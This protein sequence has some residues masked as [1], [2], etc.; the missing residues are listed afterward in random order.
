MCKFPGGKY[1]TAPKITET[2]PPHCSDGF[3]PAEGPEEKSKGHPR[4][5]LITGKTLPPR[6]PPA[7]AGIPRPGHLLAPERAPQEGDPGPPVNTWKRAGRASHARAAGQPGGAR[8]G[9][10]G[11]TSARL[12][13][14]RGAAPA[15]R[16]PPGP[17]APAL[18]AGPRPRQRGS[19][20]RG[21]GPRRRR[22]PPRAL[23]W[24][25][26]PWLHVAG[27]AR[28]A[29][30]RCGNGCGAGRGGPGLAERP[31]P[32]PAPQDSAA[33]ACPRPGPA[34]SALLRRPRTIAGGGAGAGRLTWAARARAGLPEGPRCTRPPAARAACAPGA[35][36]GSR[37]SAADLGFP[38]KPSTRQGTRP[39]GARRA[40]PRSRPG[41]R[42]LEG[43][44][45]RVAL[46]GGGGAQGRPAPESRLPCRAP[47][48]RSARRPASEQPLTLV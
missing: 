20:G 46:P 39:R 3:L 1:K 27:R 8:A 21:R 44:R 29:G 6:A 40:R 12:P 10:T 47:A 17:R 7:G 16:P 35:G 11:L 26:S 28:P 14:P 38:E 48:P 2:K 43:L 31:R 45:F 22:P 25:C 41:L 4:V 5:L 33:A 42:G 30:R 18:L 23:T 36:L 34:A 24:S 15:P 32:A 19:R 37:F 9:G 13:G